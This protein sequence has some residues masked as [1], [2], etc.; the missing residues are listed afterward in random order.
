MA[1]VVPSPA[2]AIRPNLV[3]R[4]YP[5]P[6]LLRQIRFAQSLVVLGLVSLAAG[7]AKEVVHKGKTVAQWSQDLKNPDAG[8][9]RE[10]ATALAEIGPPAEA[11]VPALTGTLAD[12][13][14][15]VRAKSAVALWSIG[16]A[17]APAVDA[18]AAA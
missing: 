7:C 15:G 12:R 8:V 17:A 10:A 14:R 4:P 1:K 11:A 18:L 16:P 2:Q 13:N 6:A 3:A 9:R 5:V